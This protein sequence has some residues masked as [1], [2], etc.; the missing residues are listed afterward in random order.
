M[1]EINGSIS[2]E[3]VCKL[4]AKS[5]GFGN[6]DPSIDALGSLSLNSINDNELVLIK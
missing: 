1:C 3:S 6:S 5:L 4:Q 2:S